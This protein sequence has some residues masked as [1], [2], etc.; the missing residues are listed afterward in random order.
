M[1]YP[2]TIILLL[3]AGSAFAQNPTGW[4]P[5]DRTDSG[6]TI[7][8][9]GGVPPFGMWEE[10]TPGN[11][12]LRASTSTQ[13]II[14]DW[15]QPNQQKVYKVTGAGVSA[16]QGRDVTVFSNPASDGP[17]ADVN[18]QHWAV[19]QIAWMK[20]DGITN[21]CGNN[22]FCPNNSI[23]R[24]EVA[25]WMCNLANVLQPGTCTP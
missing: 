18:S 6:E 10:T 4:F 11:Y 16:P 17:F 1:K 20:E 25:V 9:I 8:L 12:S 15:M 3:M 13:T 7:N 24:A 21:G 14:V 5:S 2:T 19:W 23:T 22:N